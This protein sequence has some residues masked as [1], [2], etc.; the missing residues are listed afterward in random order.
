MNTLWL[1]YIF[2]IVSSILYAISTLLWKFL[3]NG[4]IYFAQQV[5]QSLFVFISAAVYVLIKY[6][7]L[8][9]EATRKKAEIVL[10]LVGGVVTLVFAKA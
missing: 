5:F 1:G 3:T 8:R 7:S 6:K 9:I 4:G 2:T 10:P